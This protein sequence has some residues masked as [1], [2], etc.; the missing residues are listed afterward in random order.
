MPPKSRAA[1]LEEIKQ[2]V[3]RK[4]ATDSVCAICCAQK[5][6]SK[7]YKTFNK[8]AKVLQHLT[9]HVGAFFDGSRLSKDALSWN[10]EELT[11]AVEVLRSK[12]DRLRA[13][14]QGVAA[15]LLRAEIDQRSQSSLSTYTQQLTGLEA[16]EARF[17]ATKASPERLK[18]LT[19]KFGQFLVA[20]GLPLTLF[21]SP[22]GRAVAKAVAGAESAFNYSTMTS[23]VDSEMT[24]YKGWVTTMLKGRTFALAID[25][26]TSGQVKV[27][28]VTASFVN[29]KGSLQLAVLGVRAVCK[30]DDEIQYTAEVVVTIVEAVC[31]DYDLDM[32]MMSAVNSD[33]AADLFKVRKLLREKYGSASMNCVCHYFANCLQRGLSVKFSPYTAALFY[34]ARR[35]VHMVK[36]SHPALK[37][38]LKIRM[39]LIDTDPSFNTRCNGRSLNLLLSN[40]TRWTT[41]VDLLERLDMLFP[42]LSVMFQQQTK[43]DGVPRP[44]VLRRYRAAFD[45]LLH[46]QRDGTLKAL[47]DTAAPVVTAIRSMEAEKTETLPSMIAVQRKLLLDMYGTDQKF[48]DARADVTERGKPTK[49]AVLYWQDVVDLR[50]QHYEALILADKVS[51]KVPMLDDDGNPRWLVE[52]ILDER[53]RDGIEEALVKWRGYD[54]KESTWEAWKKDTALVEHVKAYRA[55]LDKPNRGATDRAM[56]K[57]L[58]CDDDSHQEEK[59][60]EN[61]A[62]ARVKGVADMSVPGETIVDEMRV[63]ILQKLL[64]SDLTPAALFDASDGA[65]KLV[66]VDT[67]SSMLSVGIIGLALDPINAPK[68]DFLEELRFGHMEHFVLSNHVMFPNAM[69]HGFIAV[70]RQRVAD[71][72]ID[73]GAS[74][75]RQRLP[76][77]TST[78]A[79]LVQYLV[80]LEYAGFR[81]EYMNMYKEKMA[82]EQRSQQAAYVP[83]MKKRRVYTVPTM[84]DFWTSTD[85]AETFPLLA[86]LATAVRAIP[87]GQ[88][89]VERV[90]S[91]VSRLH[92]PDRMNLKGTTLENLTILQFHIKWLRQMT[93]MDKVQLMQVFLNE[94]EGND[95]K[96]LEDSDGGGE[97]DGDVDHVIGTSDTGF[98]DATVDGE[99][100]TALPWG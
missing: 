87:A 12:A 3:V 49:D 8:T 63:S 11:F 71:V 51:F 90:F 30:E 75:A 57:M 44:A 45:I 62:C 20:N 39:Q 33:G 22:E 55:G 46:Y 29:E 31:A 84:E 77:V 67:A 40:M 9:S 13:A 35:L 88:A 69:L 89:A 60:K 34:Y 4:T 25:G 36:Y 52:K 73:V 1:L 7:S 68:T 6:H 38:F 96:L 82:A 86:L 27:V 10:E 28:G 58:V 99:L 53:T 50:N 43:D 93:E 85:G 95:E 26:L 19:S 83:S 47:V 54:M 23:F 66:A 78:R 18:E 21:D 5:G 41:R 91:I 48:R 80:D 94:L 98:A 15:T 2:L 76:D 59:L 92:R 70:H 65:K 37:C 14:G 24:L 64:L 56:I 42:V 72:P 97:K 79:E 100:M 81:N 32:N 74:T 61:L 17:S 16:S